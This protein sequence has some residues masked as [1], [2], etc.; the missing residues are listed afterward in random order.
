MDF[1]Y[2]DDQEAL[3]EVARK[4]LEDQAT[5]DRLREI[6]RGDERID[7]ELW[8]ELAKANLLGAALPEAHGGSGFGF[9][10]LCLLLE[11][12]GRVVAP[13]P[14]WPTLVLGALPIAR[15][16]SPAQQARW[17]PG[18]IGGD[19]FL[20]AGLTE[21]HAADPLAPTTS[22][23][24]DGSAWRLSGAKFSVP[25]AFL[26]ERL[27]VPA[28]TAEGRVGLFL[29]DPRAP[30]VRLERQEVTNREIHARLV[31]DGAPVEADG[32]LGDPEADPAVLQWVTERATVGLCALMVGV[33]DRALRITA[34]YVS[35]REQ[36]DRP[37]GSF[38]A[39]HQRA[40]DAYVDVEAMRLTLWQ[41]AFR[42]D[43]ASTAPEAVA[44]AK[45]FASEAGHA[46][47]Y[48]AQHLHGGIGVDVDYP[49]HR[50]Y[51][52]ARLIELSLGPAA[53]QLAA[54]G[55]RVARGEIGGGQA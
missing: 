21:L 22:A 18:V 11:E 39:V 50:Y 44:V 43:Q 27:L 12:V 24:R 55:E 38:Q 15:F 20:S 6:E 23:R 1:A 29:L 40:A 8:A 51:L 41:A 42:L 4:I 52:W 5:P 25:A 36:F 7:R 47:T 3:R 30:G 31:L 2:T 37:I 49:I 46:V 53:A 48:A 34:D 54:L 17:L 13:V 10:E 26:A 32:V 33:A 28:R 35:Q 45:Y 14:A 16:G 9:L 19:V